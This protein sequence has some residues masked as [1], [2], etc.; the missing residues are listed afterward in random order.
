[1]TSIKAIIDGNEISAK[2]GQTI[3][4]LCRENGIFIPT[5]CYDEQLNPIGNCG[6]CIVNIKGYGLVAS[7]ATRVG[8]AM[9][10][11]T[12]GPEVIATRRERLK[13]LLN[14]HY[15]DCKAPCIMT[16]PAG[17]DIQGYIAL[18]KIGAYKEAYD[19]IREC[20]PLPATIGR[21]CPHPC[22]SVCRRNII[23]EPL[24]ICRLKR[25][26]AD[27]VI[28]NGNKTDLLTQS[29]TK[30]KVAIVGSGPAG[31]SAAFYLALKGHE[32]TIFESLPKP[33]GMLRYGIPDYRLP[34]YIL[35]LEIENILKLGITL[36][37]EMTLGKDFTIDSLFEN[38]YDAIF[39]GLGAHKSHL[40]R[41]EGE[42]LEGVFL[43]TDFLRRVI[44]GNP[45][46]VEGKD[47]VII[48]GGNTAIDAART[49][50]RLGA[51]KVTILYRR[52]RDEM[53][54]SQW[55]VDEAE[56]EGIELHILA[57]PKKVLGKEGKVAALECIKM[58]L[59]EPDESGR[60]RPVPVEESEFTIDANMVISAIGQ[61]ADLSCLPK[62]TNIEVTSWNIVCDEDTL[63]TK[64]EGVFAGGDCV[65][66]AKTAIE[67]IAQGK[68]A[69]QSIDSYLKGMTQEKKKEQINVIKGLWEDIDKS[70]FS[71][72]VPQNR[73]RPPTLNPKERK[74]SFVEF[75]GGF[76]EEDAMAE[77]ARCLECGCKA[78]LDCELRKLATEYDVEPPQSVEEPFH[79]VDYSHPFIER[80][81]NKCI[82]CGL[83]VAT[84]RELQGVGAV[85]LS[86]RVNKLEDICEHC[87]HCMAA[88]PTGSLVSNKAQTPSHW[89]RTICPYCGCGCGIYLG[90]RGNRIVNVRGDFENPSN[91]GR[92]CVKGR[93]GYDFINHP[94]RL[95]DPLVK[96]N[97]EFVKTNWEDALNFVAEKLAGYEP[98][99]VAVLSSARCTN[100]EN[101][102]IQKF[103]R[104]VLKTN[105]VDHCA[106]L[107]HAPTVAGLVK[108]FGSGAMTNS[109]QE[110]RNAR[111]I[112]SIG[113]NTTETHP[114][115]GLEVKHAVQKGAKVIVANPKRIDLVDIADIWLSH[116]PGSDVA[117]L[118]GMC[119]II[120]D[121]GLDNQ[122]F[123]EVRCENFQGFK[124]SLESFSPEL[125][126]EVTGVPWVRIQEAARIY[127]KNSP[128]SILFAM[129]ITQHSHG[130]D[131]VLAVANLAMLT[132]NVGKESAGVNPLRGQNN[133]QGACDLGALP[134]VYP[135]YQRVNDESIQK[136]FQKVWGVQLDSNVGL[137]VTEII[138]KAHEGKI[139]AIFIVGENPMLSDPDIN[140]V[141]EA[142]LKLELLVVNDIFLSETAEFA[143]VVFP[144]ASFAEKDG[145]YTNT[146]RRVQRIRKAIEPVGG[147]KP[148]WWIVSEIAQRMKAKGFDFSCASDIMDEIA[149]L[150]PIYGG[151][152]FERIDDVGLQWPCPNKDHPGT[153]FLHEGKFSRGLG[154]FQPL[155]YK[156]PAELP[157]GEFP[158]VLTTSRMLYHYHT[159]TMTR[160]VD[161][162]NVVRPIERVEINPQDAKKLN[163]AHEDNVNVISRRGKVTGKAFVTQKV[164]VG[165]VCMSFHF[166]ETPTNALTNPV[167]DP[168]SK[169]P[170][171]KVC[172]VRVEKAGT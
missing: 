92:L 120:L 36:E 15:G 124:K 113:S 12:N 111:S 90:V 20:I 130:T 7:C 88:C 55:E 106:R 40:M 144:A 142:L 6:I 170:E 140:H 102:V 32:V 167:L 37:T 169:I 18:I 98:D 43:G 141:R 86:Y 121:E 31:L 68:K 115:I 99:E 61:V 3:I 77:A 82:A 65:L 2:A 50:L 17:V 66:G 112:F 162:L 163:I 114:I 83:C 47:V 155:E 127:A 117:I 34:Q 14:H 164:P 145:T 75:E 72:I 16:C 42:D 56:E 154:C 70:E 133:V 132:G 103:A 28:L 53:P 156:P 126:E 59:G 60:R 128:A 4:E 62:E 172:A 5:L 122:D 160:R 69:A 87:G 159:G 73:H 11:E 101:Y 96:Q 64:R 57:A 81:P 108:S 67:A 137:T 23:E 9:V 168:Q 151:I 21:V 131:N 79:P 129:G 19:L 93:F 78:A 45:P 49:S 107:C 119:K 138:N 149:T 13:Y 29:K 134:N 118:M 136:K 146:E 74:D 30:K 148:D 10:I 84:C 97:G 125:V 63:A 44:M 152:D 22:E 116:K 110:I 33:G 166:H 109:I 89:V 161:G 1:M 147:S 8:E 157:D 100:E 91:L 25:F 104:A 51:E 150:S 48:G 171:L 24:S 85:S 38:G 39:L 95:T 165:V 52:S 58:E 139:K 54:A 94:D 105:S 135:G 123:F 46:D 27:S 143:H 26:A 76:F 80:D 71:H 35:D 153:R 158:L 41:V